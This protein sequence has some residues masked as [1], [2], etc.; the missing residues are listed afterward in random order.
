MKLK[1]Q[2]IVFS[3]LKEPGSASTLLLRPGRALIPFIISKLT[4]NWT[5]KPTTSQFKRASNLVSL[6]VDSSL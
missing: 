6:V 4:T 5:Q 2:Q 1:I 3:K